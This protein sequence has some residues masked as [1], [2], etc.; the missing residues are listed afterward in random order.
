ML[1]SF[2]V[3]AALT[4]MSALPSF[5]ETLGGQEAAQLM[6]SGP[7]SFDAGS[8]ARLRA[9]GTYSFEHANGTDVGTFT[10][11][12]NGTFTLNHQSGPGAG[13]SDS[14]VVDRTNGQLSVVYTKGRFKGQAY[15]FR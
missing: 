8:V 5:A 15:R 10:V 7:R 2:F 4:V 11:T 14:F 3:G 9:D 1:K 12:R 13:K 6:V